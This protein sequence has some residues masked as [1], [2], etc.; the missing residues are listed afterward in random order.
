[1]QVLGYSAGSFW[2]SQHGWLGGGND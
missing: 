1:M 2:W